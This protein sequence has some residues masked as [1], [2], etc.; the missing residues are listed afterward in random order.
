LNDVEIIVNE[1]FDSHLVPIF[2]KPRTLNIVSRVLSVSCQTFIINS[3]DNLDHTRA[4]MADSQLTI[5]ALM[6]IDR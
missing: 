3:F 6:F 5:I 1:L 2:E 4:I